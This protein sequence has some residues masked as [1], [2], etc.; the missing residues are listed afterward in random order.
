M[1]QSQLDLHVIIN[2]VPLEFTGKTVLFSNIIQNPCKLSC[3]HVST[4][5]DMHFKNVNKDW[6]FKTE[7]RHFLHFSKYIQLHCLK[8]IVANM[9]Q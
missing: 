3:C 6:E 5:Q 8:K 4:A 2:F 9:G 1:W 7:L